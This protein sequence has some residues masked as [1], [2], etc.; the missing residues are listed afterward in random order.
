[1]GVMMME[2]IKMCGAK[3]TNEEREVYL[4]FDPV[5][6]MWTLDAFVPKYFRKALKQGWTPIREYVHDD[7]MVYGMSLIAPERAVTLR[8]VDK[9][10]LSEKQ[11]KNLGLDDE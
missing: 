10:K 3:L 8:S 11:L 2:T 5:E 6:K 1:M 9:K 4:Y 7:G